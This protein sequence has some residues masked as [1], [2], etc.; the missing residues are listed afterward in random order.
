MPVSPER[1]IR[2]LIDSG[3]MSADEVRKLQESLPANLLQGDDSQDFARELIACKK[4][5]PYQAAALYQGK[6]QQ[7][8][9]GNYV[10]LD[11]LGQGGMG[12]VLKA[13]HRRMKRIVALK[14]LSPTAIKSPDVLQRF[15]REVEAAAKLDHPNIVAALDADEARGTN[16]L[17]MQYVEG[18]DLASIVK[19]QG[20]FSV[21]NAVSCT[22]QAAEGL[23]YAHSQGITHRDVKPANLLLDKQGMVKILDMGLARIDS[24]ADGPMQADLTNTGAVM[25]TVDYMSPEQALD[26]KHADAR[27]DIYSLGCTLYYLLTGKAVYDGNTLMKKLLAH[28]EQPV[29]SLSSAR[30]E[31]PQSLDVVFQ[32]MVAK[33]PADRHRSAADLIRDLEAYRSAG[34][35]SPG[36][37]GLPA[38]MS[39]GSPSLGGD[40]PAVHEFLAAISQTRGAARESKRDESAGSPETLAGAAGAHLISTDPISPAGRE[41]LS[42]LRQRRR[43][44]RRT[45]MLLGIAAIAFLAISAGYWIWKELG[46]TVIVL[47][48]PESEHA[49]TAIVVDGAQRPVPQSGVVRLPGPPGRRTLRL[50]RDGYQNI[51]VSWEMARAEQR[52]FR[53]EWEPTPES[54]RHR[55]FAALAAQARQI[56]KEL[57]TTAVSGDASAA[58]LRQQ[59]LSFRSRWAG[60][61]ESVAA[62]A[63]L[64]QIPSPFDR[65]DPTQIDSA[66]R[67]VWGFDRVVA[68]LGDPRFQNWCNVTC[69]TF[70][71]DG[72]F[73]ATGSYGHAV[74]IW[75]VRSGAE[76]TA[77]KLDE[78]GGGAVYF[79]GVRSLAYAPDGA[80]LAVA[81]CYGFVALF[82]AL[83]GYRRVTI[84][85]PEAAHSMA[86]SRKGSRLVCGLFNGACIV[87]DPETGESSN[88]WT[89]HTGIVSGVDLIDGGEMSVSC[90]IDG[91]VKVWDT[92]SGMVLHS[93]ADAKGTQLLCVALGPDAKTVAAGGDGPSIWLWNLDKADEPIRI[94][95][96][97]RSIIRL[98]FADQGQ[99][100]L[101]VGT[102]GAIT[103]WDIAS[104]Q[105]RHRLATETPLACAALCAEQPLVAVAGQDQRTRLWNLQTGVEHHKPS[106]PRYSA[107][108]VNP[109]CRVIAAGRSDGKIDLWDVLTAQI[110]D[111]IDAGAAAVSDLAYSPDGMTFAIGDATGGVKI[112]KHAGGGEPVELAGHQGV[113]TRVRYSPDGKYLLT[114]GEDKMVHIWNADDGTLRDTIYDHESPSNH[115]SRITGVAASPDGRLFAA[116]SGGNYIQLGNLREGTVNRTIRADKDSWLHAVSFNEDSSSIFAGDENVIR[117]WTLASG[118]VLP[119]EP[120]SGHLGGVGVVAVSSNGK[121]LVSGGWDGTVR[122]WEIGKTL[123][124][125]ET[126]RLAPLSG[127]IYAGALANDGR[128]FATF[129][130]NGTIYVLRLSEGGSVSYLP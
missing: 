64:Q 84:E 71:P 80:T 106:A 93:L 101:S 12:M 47:E 61:A 32:R 15:R 114:G 9:L 100:L 40:D 30:P 125:K 44:E 119:S 20:P 73:V 120:A 55:E 76:K 78:G 4:L 130:S 31:I 3:L 22:L 109:D 124:L 108:A 45:V 121:Q 48:W 49:G 57:P 92:Q 77:L 59:I 129:N 29:P 105:P 112:W 18:S 53:P 62:G 128:H 91:L 36:S 2:Q 5:T 81:S 58:T 117:M 94:E 89:L 99:S 68:V 96:Q 104:H 79:R 7:L 26:T 50:T 41:M 123:R 11:K 86:F 34:A 42:S 90:G 63:L 122:I 21:E 23:A 66:L 8:V 103:H 118:Q 98:A 19:K 69:L 65:L 70:S 17:V 51:E 54:I 95:H 107:V 46:A 6:G 56:V 74:K 113:V 33:N 111:S 87:I 127:F 39:A 24:G 38:V 25:G 43:G 28:R 52:T 10:I 72:R 116:S 115:E 60:S 85:I 75:E 37:P 110:S 1:F 126:I 97:D 67:P 14:V 102:S 83:T 35:Q 88:S 27:S 13:E 82:D 16:F